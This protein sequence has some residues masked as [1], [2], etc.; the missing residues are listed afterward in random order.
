MT[1]SH[2]DAAADSTPVPGWVAWLFA[3][4]GIL[5]TV[6]LALGSTVC[7]TDASASCPNW[8]GCY[9]GRLSPQAHTQPV[10]EF[11]HRVISSSIGL[12]GLASVVA[13]WLH[14]RRN[15]MLVVL[16]LVALLGALASGVFGM[17]TIRWG[18]NKFEA[19]LDLLAAL[20]SMGAI[21][22]AWFVARRPDSRWHWNARS[23]LGAA[24]VGTL[25]AGHFLAVLVSGSGS[26]SR[27]MGWA[28][29][30]R[31]AGDGPLVAWGLQQ[32]VMV[33][34]ELL[35]VAVLVAR[36]RHRVS[37]WDL[38]LAILVVVVL[39]TGILISAAGAQEGLDV[40]H[41][42]GTVLILAL[43]MTGTMRDSVN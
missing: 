6:T 33:V 15:R 35:T 7:A 29:F 39:A 26:L 12:F 19:A 31:G 9:V 37:A 16:P 13:G 14:R 5:I 11:V 18:I 28:L 30:V 23:R 32:A 17:M 41:A 36:L 25:V 42:V 40:A 3:I 10:V 34:G 38:L 20:I 43:V 4:T 1:P 22:R 24:A 8:P 2:S 27:C 21:W